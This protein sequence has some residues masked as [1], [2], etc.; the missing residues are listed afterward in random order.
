MSIQLTMAQQK[1]VDTL[2][3]NM[4][5]IFADSGEATDL[6]THYIKL[7]ND[8]PIASRPYRLAEQKRAE[9]KT[10]I[11][12]MLKDNIIEHSNSPWAAPVVMIPKKTGGHR[13][14]IDYRKLNT[15]TIPDR[16]PLPRIDDLLH[17]A[18]SSKFMSTIDLCSGYWQVKMNE[19]DI[20]KTAF[21]TP[22]G[23]YQFKRMPFGLINAPATFQR[24]IDRFQISL[25]HIAILATHYIKLKKNMPF[26]RSTDASGYA[27]EAV[28]I[29]GEDAEEHPSKYASRRLIPPDEIEPTIE[30]RRRGRPRK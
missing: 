3:T 9:L 25:P 1:E 7:K 6:A 4:A 27:I 11:G 5:H 28:L 29:Q 16:Y 18:R 14:C 24:M 17:E 10:E 15:K 23:C 8:M 22:T 26:I 19:E 20:P 2:K 21:V 30:K 12:K 13:I